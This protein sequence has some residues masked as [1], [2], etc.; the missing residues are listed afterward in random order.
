MQQKEKLLFKRL[1]SFKENTFDET[2]LEAATPAVL[3]QLFFNRMH[4]VAY[5][6]LKEFGLLGKVS[7]EFR[8]SLKIAYD[9]NVIKNQ[10][11]F[12]CVEYVMQ[13]LSG[14]QCEYAMLK[15]A[16]LC[17]L[18]PE[19]FRTSNDIDLLVHPKSVSNIGEALL[20]AGFSQGNIRNGKFEPATRREIIESKM[21]RGETVPYIKEIN[22]PEMKF[23]EVDVNFSLDYKPGE[24]AVLDSMLRGATTEQL[25]DFSVRTLG[26]EDFFLHLCSHLHKEAT[27]L[28]WVEMMRDMTLYKYADIYVLLHNAKSKDVDSLFQRAYEL[29]LEKICAFA[30]LQAS[31][32]FSNCNQH[33]ANVAEDVLKNDPLFIH[34]VISPKERAVYVFQEKNVLERL[35]M[36][37]RKQNLEVVER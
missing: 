11:F 6:T 26:K 32:L 28:P 20:K 30:I 18:Y 23:L 17:R 29:G 31:Q 19:G 3:G 2:L 33:A 4:A 9:H 21:T 12:Q 13:A 7:R 15:G 35:F 10:S 5:G 22:L 34:S 14:C 36:H 24:T 16:Y 25:D 8:N 27:T 1:C 37:N